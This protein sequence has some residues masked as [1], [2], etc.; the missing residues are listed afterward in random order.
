MRSLLLD[1]HCHLDECRDPADAARRAAQS[2]IV[3]VAVTGSPGA[4]ARMKSAFGER[5]NVRVALGL[6]PMAL[7]ALGSGEV[8]RFL[9]L[10]PSADYV[11]EVGLDFSPSDSEIRRQQVKVF[12]ELLSSTSATRSVW[13]VHSRRAAR[14]VI[15]RLETAGVTAILHWFTG[16]KSLI[17]R[18]AGAGLYFSVN[19]AMVGSRRGQALIEAMP[20]E[21]V[22]TETDSPYVDSPTGRRD[23]TDVV[24]VVD[25]LARIWGASPAETR[26]IVFENMARAFAQRRAHSRIAEDRS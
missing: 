17:D 3:I 19:A 23:P 25:G 18:A 7:A 24:G 6:H 5:K 22:L 20:R 15:E 2:G 4:Y 14:E 12:E 21:R 1:A 11:G 16:P 8:D 9:S 13:S 26:D 10:L